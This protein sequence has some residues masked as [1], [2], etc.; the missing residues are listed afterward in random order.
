MERA[1]AVLE[2]GETAKPWLRAYVLV[3]LL[4]G[5]RTEEVRALRW[6]YVVA[7][8]ER[9]GTWS[10]VKEAGWDHSEFGIYVWRSVRT[11][12]DT[13]TPRSRRT[14]KLP[15]R[16]VS[17][18]RALW[19]HQ[20]D[21]REKA[22][23]RWHDDDLVFATR[24]GAKLSAANVRREVRRVIKRAGL[25]PEEWTPR[26]LRHSFVSLLS[27]DGLPIE[28]IARVIGHAGGSAVTE[29]IYRQQIRP[30]MQEGTVIMDRIFAAPDH[31]SEEP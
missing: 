20:S 31:S 8:D 26:E 17:A 11:G 21:V 19:A 3:S 22:G 25:V 7:L 4:V 14:L 18:L 29:K 1:A 10:S 28:H 16:C 6:A 13:K 5:L 9:T 23:D 24:T 30:V 15:Q 27:A 2:A 12:G